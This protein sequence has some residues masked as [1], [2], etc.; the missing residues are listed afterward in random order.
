[1][2]SIVS[3]PIGNL[4]DITLRALETLKECDAIVCE[5]T[6]VTGK[7]LQMLDLPKKELISLHGY[8]DTKKINA[9]LKRLAEGAHLALVSDA[10]TPCISDPGYQLVSVALRQGDTHQVEVIPG[11]SAF[12]A[13]LSA[14]GLPINQFLYLGFLPLKKGRQTLLASFTEEKR[15][16]V[17]YES[18]HRIEKTLRELVG[19]LRDQP[20]RD[21]VICRELTKM[22]EEILRTTVAELASIS[23]T[24]KGEFV[25]VI[26]AV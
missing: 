10:G 15:T 9:I 8:S 3:T 21:I 17:F 2:L 20:N 5:D 26:G 24:Q 4:G 6:R 18:V 7:L 23:L 12:L 22:H 13:A 16:I 14:S 1:M 25:I 19:A 11:P